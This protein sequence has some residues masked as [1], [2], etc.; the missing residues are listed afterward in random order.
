MAQSIMVGGP[1]AVNKEEWFSWE[2]PMSSEV[3]I[4]V[5]NERVANLKEIVEGLAGSVRDSAE[6]NVQQAEEF[7]TALHESQ[8]KLAAREAV[9][10]IEGLKKLVDNVE[11]I[12]T[13]VKWLK[14]LILVLIT[15]LV[16][17]AFKVFF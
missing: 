4:E 10:S 8:M 16:G 14:A 6:I 9:L 12:L 13:D 15:A 17:L 5:L 1:F 3:T 7:S 11:A 2:V